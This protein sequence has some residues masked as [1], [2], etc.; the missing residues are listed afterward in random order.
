MNTYFLIAA[1]ALLLAIGATPVIRRLALRYDM[2]DKPAARKIHS[3][4]V[5]LLGGAV[6]YV[7]FMVVLLLFGDRHY[8]VTKW[9][10]SSSAPAS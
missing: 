2:V 9:S 4:P 5:P 10:A 1:S 7:A 3:A 6:V 8:V